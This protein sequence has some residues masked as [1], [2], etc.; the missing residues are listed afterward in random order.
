MADRIQFYLNDRLITSSEPAG[1]LVLDFLRRR[2]ELCGTKEGCR[3][4]DCGACTVLVGTL[5][6]NAVRY[7]PVPSCMVPLGEMQGKHL[8]TIEGL[9]RAEATPVQQAIVDTGATQCGFCTPGIVVSFT[10]LLL[11]Q[12][13]AIDDEAIKTALSGHLCRCTGY[14]SLKEAGLR[15]ARAIGN[16][17]DVAVLIE[18]GALPEYFS[19]MPE[20][21]SRIKSHA[22]R[23]PDSAEGRIISGGT[24]IY[25]QEGETLPD[26]RV[27]L[28]NLIPE[29]RGIRRE[30]GQIH[31]G[32]LTTFEEFSHHPAVHAMVPEIQQYMHLVASWQIRNR[33][34]LGGNIVNA[35]PIGDVSIL[36]LAL[37]ANLILESRAGRRKVPLTEFYKGYK[38]LDLRDG[39]VLC[40][41]VVTLPERGVRVN[42]EKVSKRKC[43]DIASVNSAICLKVQNGRIASVGLSMGGVAPIPLFLEDTCRYLTGKP[44]S[45]QTVKTAISRVQ[46]EISPISDIRGSAGYKRLLARQLMLAH[47]LKI[48]PEVLS[49]RDFS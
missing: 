24:D 47:F 6:G 42:F 20:K 22:V 29:F 36:L 12:D 18:H 11:R 44:V 10:G 43:L 31:F 37:Q 7:D 28:L 30:N 1:L 33:A 19:S 3:E 38:K 35:S 46:R 27:T 16:A 26:S 9:N 15:F 48:F 45:L 13:G 40:E 8:V 41:I 14:R 21:L 49:M 5:H 39:E 2:L 23:Q 34:T 25:V 32:A 4:G 17:R